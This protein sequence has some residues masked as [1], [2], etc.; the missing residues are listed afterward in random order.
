MEEVNQLNP[1]E[2]K[3][4]KTITADYFKSLQFWQ[5]LSGENHGTVFYGGEQ[6]QKRSDGLQVLPWRSVGEMV[7]GG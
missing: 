3:S 1:I 5:Q 2:I 4:G 6:V 7:E